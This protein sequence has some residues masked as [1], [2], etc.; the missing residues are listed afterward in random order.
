MHS[1]RS[2]SNYM[3]VS[4]VPLMGTRACVVPDS[5]YIISQ[6]VI[7]IRQLVRCNIDKW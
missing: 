3:A 5:K 4:F 2:S 1:L 7:S 6:A